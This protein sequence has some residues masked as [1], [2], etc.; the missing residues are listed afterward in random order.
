M[1]R[2]V[3]AAILLAAAIGI[4][5]LVVRGFGVADYLWPAPSRVARTLAD[6]RSLL[7]HNGWITLREMILGLAIAVAAGLAIGIALH[8]SA[9][10]RRAAYPLL[11]GSQAM[12]VVLLAPILVVAFGFD[13]GP[14]LALVALVCFFPVVVGTVDGLRSVD[15]ELVRMMRTLHASRLAVFRRVELP[16]ALPSI[17]SGTR[18]A[19]TYAAVGAVFGEWSGSTSGLGW[20]ML[21]SQPALLTSRIFAAVVI[22]AA[23]SLALFALVSVAERVLVPWVFDA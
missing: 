9:H 3:P 19:A 11:V 6:D 18:I 23:I 12:P 22:L 8:A 2:Y 16:G 10:L 15:P 7:F 5:E 21:Q 14:K 13:I 17:F 4:W 20:V 1:K